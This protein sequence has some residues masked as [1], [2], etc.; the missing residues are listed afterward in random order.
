MKP[1]DE[2]AWQ[3]RIL[4]DAECPLCAREG[5][6]LQRLDA[7][8]GR[9]QLEDLSAPEFDPTRY[10]LDQETVEARIHGVLPDG[11]VVEGVE[12]FA[13]AYAAVGVT[14]ISALFEWRGARWLMDRLYLLF[15]K[16]RLRITGRTP[17]QCAT[18]SG[19][20]SDACVLPDARS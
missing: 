8:R 18:E 4:F 13:R 17:K 15:A 7:G 12:V 1:I 16:Y 2:D 14:W 5:R 3:I 19:K 20:R 9:I 11:S 6:Y 10:G